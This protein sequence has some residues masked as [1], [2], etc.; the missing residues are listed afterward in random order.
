MTTDVSVERAVRFTGS[1]SPRRVSYCSWSVGHEDEGST[2][3]RNLGQNLPVETALYLEGATLSDSD[4]EQ[5]ESM[6]IIFFGREC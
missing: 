4:I 1:I 3:L 2:P 6:F 5:G